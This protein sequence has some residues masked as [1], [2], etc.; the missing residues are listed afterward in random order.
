MDPLGLPFGSL[1]A[2]KMA[3]TSLGIPLG[4]AKSRSRLVFFGPRAVQERSKRSPRPLQEASMSP[5]RS[6]KAPRSLWRQ[7]LTPW[8]PSGRQKQPFGEPRGPARSTPKDIQEHFKN[9]KTSLLCQEF[10]KIFQDKPPRASFSERKPRSLHD[11]MPQCARA[12]FKGWAAVPR[13]RR[14][15]LLHLMENY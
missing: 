3:E 8:N 4:A 14:L 2:P 6:R 10:S 13:R 11:C 15:G 12:G 5:R 1:L 7:I 9:S